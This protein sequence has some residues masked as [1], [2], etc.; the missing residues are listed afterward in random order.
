MKCISLICIIYNVYI[1]ILKRNL[2]LS[3]TIIKQ[4]PND[5]WIWLLV[6]LPAGMCQI[7]IEGHLEAGTG[8]EIL[9]DDITIRSCSLVGK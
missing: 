4:G 3:A 8:N 2:F 6:E 5:G 7:I 9:M 1:E